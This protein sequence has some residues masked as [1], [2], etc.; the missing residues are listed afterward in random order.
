M[1]E[2]NLKL[3][4]A[5][6]ALVEGITQVQK[7]ICDVSPIASLRCIKMEGVNPL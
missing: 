3:K 6:K 1:T 2:T 4:V 7:A 5:K